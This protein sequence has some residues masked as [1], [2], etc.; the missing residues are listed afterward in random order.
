MLNF[1][2]GQHLPFS[3]FDI[4]MYLQF[5]EIEYYRKTM[6]DMK[7]LNSYSISVQKLLP[8]FVCFVLEI[9]RIFLS[10]SV[11]IDIVVIIITVILLLILLL[12]LQLL[13]LFITIIIIVINII[14]L[15]ILLLVLVKR[16]YL[17]LSCLFWNSIHK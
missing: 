17:H 1:H 14:F 9:K 11:I 10:I 12:V 16:I 7:T 15:L 4:I 3:R 6:P 13:L 8:E 2:V 5:H